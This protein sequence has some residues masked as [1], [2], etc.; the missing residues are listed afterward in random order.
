M[1]MKKEGFGVTVK[2]YEKA[3]SNAM[4]LLPPL[5]D[6]DIELVKRNPSL[7]WWQK[8]NLIHQIKTTKFPV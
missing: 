6:E 8:M 1:P 2:E 3:L 7:H 4:K 5:G